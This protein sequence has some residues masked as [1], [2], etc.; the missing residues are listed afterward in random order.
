M[1][2]LRSG[3]I[4]RIIHPID[5]LFHHISTLKSINHLTVLVS[6]EKFQSFISVDLNCNITL[7]AHS[8][9]TALLIKYIHI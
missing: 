4:N 8:T 6:V 9:P 7:F 1:H 2:I 5:S 3:F